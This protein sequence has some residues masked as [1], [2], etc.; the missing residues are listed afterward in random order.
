MPRSHDNK[1]NGLLAEATD[2]R[3]PRVRDVWP[4]LLEAGDD[5]KVGTEESVPKASDD[6]EA[7]VVRLEDGINTEAIRVKKGL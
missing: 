7:P 2:A 3:D 5:K 1:L 6:P 4:A